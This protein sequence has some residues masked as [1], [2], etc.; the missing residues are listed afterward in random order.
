MELLILC[1]Q[2]HFFL[3]IE[4]S[5]YL[6]DGHRFLYSLLHVRLNSIAHLIKRN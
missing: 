4:Y 6:L 1:T 3:Y 2:A 5:E